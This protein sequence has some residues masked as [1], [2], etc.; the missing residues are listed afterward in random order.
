M[1]EY[2]IGAIAIGILAFI[3]IDLYIHNRFKRSI[4]DLL[5]DALKFD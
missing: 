1:T 4:G 2:I 3:G 5:K